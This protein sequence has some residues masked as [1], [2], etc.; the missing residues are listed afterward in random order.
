MKGLF[1]APFILFLGHPFPCIDRDS[2]GGDGGGGV[3]LGRKNIAGRPADFSAEFLEG[4]NQNSGLNGHVEATCNA[5]TFEGLS[6]TE[7]F[8]QCHQARH[9]GFG[10]T[11]FFATP[12]GEG[13]VFDFVL[14]N[15]AF[16]SFWFGP[17]I[18]DARGGSV[19]FLQLKT[20]LTP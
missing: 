14:S 10:Q 15:S 20:T 9:F 17:Q 16:H 11:N 6:G 3:V 4:F 5:G 12:F 7:F 13:N 19:V 1:N 18:Y 2:G 8:T